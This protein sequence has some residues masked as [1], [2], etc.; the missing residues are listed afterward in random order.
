MLKFCIAVDD[1]EMVK[2]LCKNNK[3]NDLNHIENRGHTLSEKKL[4]AKFN[5]QD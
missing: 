5:V 1:L 2:I 3:L 4:I